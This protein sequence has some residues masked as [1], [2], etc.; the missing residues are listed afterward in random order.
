MELVCPVP[1]IHFK[2]VENKKKGGKGVYSCPCYYYS[3]RCGTSGWASYIVSV[4]L[5]VGSFSA[6]HWIKRA[7]ALLMSLDY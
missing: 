3:N 4:D 7:V 6:D 1:S 5:K 2:P